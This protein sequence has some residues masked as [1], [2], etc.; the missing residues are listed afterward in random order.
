MNS[1]L[2]KQS[3]VILSLAFAF[4]LSQAAP[5]VNVAPATPGDD[6]A[7]AGPN[8][9]TND[10]GTP[11]LPPTLEN[12]ANDHDIFVANT[13]NLILGGSGE[14]SRVR[15]LKIGALGNAGSSPGGLYSVI[16]N[17]NGRLTIQDGGSLQVTSTFNIGDA[18]PYAGAG[19]TDPIK[20]EMFVTGGSVTS[21][22]IWVGARRGDA[23]HGGRTEGLLD[24]SGGSMNVSGSILIG[25]ASN[26]DN[27]E[28]VNG[29]A[30]FTGGSLNMT[31]GFFVGVL[32]NGEWTAEQ[33]ANRGFGRLEFG[34]EANIDIG[35]T[36]EMRFNSELVFELGE[37]D[38]FN[39][40]EIASLN[41]YSVAQ[42]TVDGSMLPYVN[43][44]TTITL[45]N[46]DTLTS[47]AQESNITLAGFDPQY[48]P[49]IE[50]TDNQMVLH[51]IPEPAAI[52]VFIGMIAFIVVIFLRRRHCHPA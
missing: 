16:T 52:S 29:L 31:G 4:A 49:S 14:S 45:A 11:V 21:G 37:T 44:Y 46:Y 17:P 27:K 15:F 10:Q 8:T 24:Q 33:L 25:A 12:N 7:Y 5:R 30:R 18:N 34:P 2:K 26:I 36:L 35:G 28:N 23:T 41:F 6:I 20:G 51:L 19:W 22:T 38:G 1:C 48:I 47:P 32:H 13:A 39:P 42:L 50:F 9:W 3:I 43:D 40:I